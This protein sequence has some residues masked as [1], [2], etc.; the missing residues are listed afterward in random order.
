[1]NRLKILKILNNKNKMNKADIVEVGK[2][3]KIPITGTKDV[4]LNRILTKYKIN[5]N[6]IYSLVSLNHMKNMLKKSGINPTGTKKSIYKQYMNLL[7]KQD[8]GS[9]SKRFII[10]THAEQGHREYME[11]YRYIFQNDSIVFSAVFDGHGGKECAAYLKSNL[12]KNFKQ[13]IQSYRNINNSL[14][15]LFFQ[16]NQDY[17]RSGREAGSTCNLLII[18]KDKKI[19]FVANT[20]DSRV[21]LCTKD[22]EVMQL[23][24]DHKPTDI[25]EKRRIEQ[26]GGFVRGSRVNGILAMSRAFGDKDISEYLTS[27]PDIIKGN[28]TSKVDFFVQA[29]DGLF[30]VMS[31]KKICNFINDARNSGVPLTNIPKLLVNHSINIGSQDNVSVII[32]FI[33]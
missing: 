10:S 8:G 15:K 7:K 1:M 27:E 21:I 11:D 16:T 6:Q 22:G 30:D 13:M 2:L 4:I 18:N 17:L 9:K 28:L 33:S 19:F 12:F 31:N 24:N 26:S 32:T 14:K 25:K 5:R 20:G 29:S 3:A 23:S